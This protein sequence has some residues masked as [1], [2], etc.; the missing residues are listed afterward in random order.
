MADYV[1]IGGDGKEYGPVSG[2]DLRKWIS[3]G[4]LS[5]QSLAKAESDAEFRPLATFPE[6]ADAFATPTAPGMPPTLTV[7]EDGGRE[8]A[9]R[10]VKAPAVALIITAILYILLVVAS[11]VVLAAFGAK[12]QQ[13]Y[14]EMPNGVQ[15]QKLLQSANSPFAVV[16]DVL[17]LVLSVLILI[18]ATKM[19][20]LRSYEFSMTAA[21]VAMLPCVTPCCF[22]GLPFGIWALAVLAKPGVKSHFS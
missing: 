9:L 2:G 4:R 11:W 8:A 21:I 19:K 3:E 17:G 18:G 22:I 16:G 13:F 6:F 20:S 12:L 14:S 1:I 15:M 10:Q 7:A 5:A